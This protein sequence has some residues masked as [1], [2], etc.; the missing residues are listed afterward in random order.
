MKPS[1]PM[2]QGQVR[3]RQETHPWPWEWGL[4]SSTGEDTEEPLSSDLWVEEPLGCKGYIEVFLA[5]CTYSTSHSP[6]VGPGPSGGGAAQPSVITQLTGSDLLSALAL[7]I[8]Q[9]LVE[10]SR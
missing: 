3:T 10:R 7:S 5:P 2:R 1:E 9:Q 6:Q 4:S 8:P